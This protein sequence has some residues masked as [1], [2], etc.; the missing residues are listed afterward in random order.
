MV[1]F[2]PSIYAQAGVAVSTAA[3][4]TALVAAVNIVGNLAAGRLLQV[5]TAPFTLLVAGFAAMG[6]GAMAAFGVDAAFWLQYLAVLAF[7][8]LG[9]LIPGTLFSLAVRLAPSVA[10]VPT[11]VGW[12]QQWSAL[13]QF[14][15]PPLVAWVVSQ[16]GSWQWTWMV[17][18]G[19]SL[20]GVALAWQIHSLANTDV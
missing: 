3:W 6:V 5:G 7:S 19:F 2:L 15:G 10:T 1:G 4:L 16:T 17:T 11:A 13:G 20:A 8:M 9:G 14:F 12:M 18:G